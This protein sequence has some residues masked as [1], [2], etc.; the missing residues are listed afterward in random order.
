ME[1]IFVG[2]YPSFR[3]MIDVVLLLVLALAAKSEACAQKFS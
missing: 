1:L 2:R 3:R